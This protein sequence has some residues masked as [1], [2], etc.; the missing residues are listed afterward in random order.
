M[1]TLVLDDPK[2][3]RN[4]KYRYIL[5]S[6]RNY[7]WT[8]YDS[9]ESVNSSDPDTHLHYQSKSVLSVTIFPSLNYLGIEILRNF[10]FNILP[11]RGKLKH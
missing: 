11:Y 8:F 2:G 5:I 4:E 3:D 1:T 7:L 10:V 6:D 9:R